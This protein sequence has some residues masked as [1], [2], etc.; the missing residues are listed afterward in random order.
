MRQ[1]NSGAEFPGRRV[2][3]SQGHL[4]PTFGR[5]LHREQFRPLLLPIACVSR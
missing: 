4:P 5:L 3:L 1:N 2:S